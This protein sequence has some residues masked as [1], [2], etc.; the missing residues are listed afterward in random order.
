[1][2]KGLAPVIA[3]RP[4]T[5]ILGSMPGVASLEKKQYYGH[6]RN[7]F[8]PLMARLLGFEKHDLYTRN[9]EQ[10]EQHGI[11]IWDV[12]GECERPGSLDSAIVKGSV[13]T[14]PIPELIAEHS[15]ITRIGLNGGTAA[16]LFKRHCLPQ[17]DTDRIEVFY[18]PSTSP[19]NARMNF[20][21]KCK[22]WQVMLS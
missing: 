9:V 19:A 15:G 22:A 17:I 21:T 5:L 16:S 8:W 18:L 20:E 4:T 6:P 1:V 2:L 12:I 10:I 11:A 13:R 14:N 7:A 3:N